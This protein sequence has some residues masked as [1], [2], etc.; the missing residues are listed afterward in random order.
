M[1]YTDDVCRTGFSFGQ[2]LRM[3][4]MFTLYRSP[5]ASAGEPPHL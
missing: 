3:Q 4:N 2:I 5:G 1:D